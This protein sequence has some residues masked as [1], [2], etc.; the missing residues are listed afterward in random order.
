MKV[1]SILT[2]LVVPVLVFAHSDC[3]SSR[4]DTRTGT[5]QADASM[6]VHTTVESYTLDDLTCNNAGPGTPFI[7]WVEKPD[8]T[9]IYPVHI[10]WEDAP[11]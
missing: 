3:D 5:E 2:M 1:L 4:T 9:I 10:Q 8:G 7:C 11:R 6:A